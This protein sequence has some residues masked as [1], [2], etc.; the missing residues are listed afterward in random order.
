MTVK[1]Y[2]VEVHDLGEHGTTNVIWSE[3]FADDLFPMLQDCGLKLTEIDGWHPNEASEVVDDAIEAMIGEE[4]GVRESEP[5]VRNMAPYKG[6]YDAA[7]SLL[8]RFQ[9]ALRSVKAQEDGIILVNESNGYYG[10]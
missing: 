3:H 6:G 8:V 5:K 9:Y 2:E 1:Y 4:Q 7:L 10:H